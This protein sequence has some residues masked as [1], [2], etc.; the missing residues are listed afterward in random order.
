MMEEMEAV[1]PG[2]EA[3]AGTRAKSRGYAAN[4]LGTPATN[5]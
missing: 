5:S 4:A 1:A 2:G 3:E